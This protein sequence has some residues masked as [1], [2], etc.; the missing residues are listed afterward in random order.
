[1]FWIEALDGGN[2]N[3]KVAF[4]D[5]VMRLDAPFNGDPVE[6]QRMPHR[7]ARLSFQPAT[8]RTAQISW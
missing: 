7:F 2:P 8:L 4:R 1:M 5:R 3:N 6:V